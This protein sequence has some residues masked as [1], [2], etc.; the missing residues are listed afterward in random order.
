MKLVFRVH[1]IERMFSRS[2]SVEDVRRAVE[3]GEMIEDYPDDK[4]YPSRLLLGWLGPEPLHVVIAENKPKDE[5][6]VVT[7]YKP[8]PKIW[9]AGFRRRKIP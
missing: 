7:V 9:E 2:I 1:A 3:N 5:V 4:P 6:I 8:D